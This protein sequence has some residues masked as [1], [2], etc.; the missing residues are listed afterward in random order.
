MLNDTKKWWECR[1]VNNRIGYVPNTIV[2]VIDHGGEHSNPHHHNGGGRALDQQ[3]FVRPNAAGAGV[4]GSNSG[5]PSSSFY[6][7]QV[8]SFWPLHST[9]ADGSISFQERGGSQTRGGS[10]SPR[11]GYGPRPETPD[12]LRNRIGKNGEFRYF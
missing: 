10:A 3:I 2:T 1:N 5:P 9:L 6:V 8:S 11:G 12:Y 4:N 7:Q